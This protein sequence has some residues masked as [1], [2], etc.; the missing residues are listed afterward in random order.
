M[1]VAGVQGGPFQGVEAV[2]WLRRILSAAGS[3][4]PA[5]SGLRHS[6][7]PASLRRRVGCSLNGG[8][9]K[10]ESPAYR[11]VIIP[12]KRGVLFPR[13]NRIQFPVEIFKVE[14]DIIQLP[15]INNELAFDYM[16]DYVE[17]LEQ[18]YVK[19]LDAY[20]KVTGLDSYKLTKEEKE[21]LTKDYT[22]QTKRLENLFTIHF[23][24]RSFTDNYF[25]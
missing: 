23:R 10:R 12:P 3:I 1:A 15:T 13:E 8:E 16:Q 4:R 2:R 5:G 17:E 21:S 14:N 6:C 20:L 11:V 7:G 9:T 22:F 19:E 25:N 24:F 18:D